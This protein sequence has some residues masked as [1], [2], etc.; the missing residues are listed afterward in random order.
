MPTRLCPLSFLSEAS[1]EVSEIRCG[2]ELPEALG[3]GR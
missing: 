2:G 1:P 3:T